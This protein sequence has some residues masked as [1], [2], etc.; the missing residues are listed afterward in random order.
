MINPPL[1][2]PKIFIMKVEGDGIGAVFNVFQVFDTCQLYDGSP[3]F[4]NVFHFISFRVTDT[5]I[6]K[7]VEKVLYFADVSAWR[8]LFSDFVIIL[9]IILSFPTSTCVGGLL[10]RQV[11]RVGSGDCSGWSSSSVGSFVEHARGL[12]VGDCVWGNKMDGT[13]DVKCRDERVCVTDNVPEMFCKVGL[14]CRG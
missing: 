5:K 10:T 9:A 8:E 7:N 4:F 14:E 11:E 1:L 12:R 2:V 3:Q 13:L 6:Y